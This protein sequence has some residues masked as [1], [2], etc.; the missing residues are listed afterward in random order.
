MKAEKP[1]NTIQEV[2]YAIIVRPVNTYEELVQQQRELFSCFKIEPSMMENYEIVLSEGNY[3]LQKRPTPLSAMDFDIDGRDKSVSRTNKT[4]G[5]CMF[6]PID[7]PRGKYNDAHRIM[8]GG[9]SVND[10][11]S[12]EVGETTAIATPV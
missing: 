6:G 3:K 4:Y 9:D 8:V 5:E 12:V 1:S 7:R 11:C 10:V 2:A